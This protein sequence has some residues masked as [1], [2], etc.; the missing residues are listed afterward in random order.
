ME[1]L[2]D[3]KRQSKTIFQSL[4]PNNSPSLRGK[5][6]FLTK[7]GKSEKKGGA[8]RW[9]RTGTA[10]NLPPLKDSVTT[11]IHNVIALS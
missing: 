11:P 6:K 8:W 10:Q 1:S 2:R 3:E 7:L 4:T 9:V 5:T